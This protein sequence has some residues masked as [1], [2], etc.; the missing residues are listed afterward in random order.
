MIDFFPLFPV[1]CLLSITFAQNSSLTVSVFVS[2]NGN[3]SLAG[4]TA[5]TAVYSAARFRSIVNAAAATANATSSRLSLNVFFG[6]GVYKTECV[7]DV[8]S[9]A[10]NDALS[11]VGDGTEFQCHGAA[12]IFV[13]SGYWNNVTIRGLSVTNSTLRCAG[14]CAALRSVGSVRSLTLTDVHL[15]SVT[16]VLLD[17]SSVPVKTGLSAI[18]AVLASNLTVANCTFRDNAVVVGNIDTRST[19]KSLN[20]VGGAIIAVVDWALLTNVSFVG[21]QLVS[22]KLTNVAIGG[23]AVRFVVS[24]P[25]SMSSVASIVNCTFE[26]NYVASR[27]CVVGAAVCVSSPDISTQQ[28]VPAPMSLLV[29]DSTFANNQLVTNATI[30]AIM[31]G[32]AIGS[33]TANGPV[34]VP[35]APWYVL[36]L[37]VD[38]VTFVANSARRVH[39]STMPKVVGGVVQAWTMHARNSRFVGN[40]ISD[41]E[42]V[43]GGVFALASDSAIV[44]CTMADNR[45]GDTS[46]FLGSVGAFIYVTYS[47]CF[48]ATT[49]VLNVVGSAFWNNSMSQAPAG[50]LIGG[51]GG[52]LA[53]DLTACTS[54]AVEIV[55]STF[56]DYSASRGCG[57]VCV[58]SGGQLSVSGAL[59]A[60]NSAEFASAVSATDTAS[61]SFDRTR[62]EHNRATGMAGAVGL[63][64]A[65]SLAISTC[66]FD[67]NVAVVRGDA[68][69]LQGG[70]PQV[71]AVNTTFRNNTVVCI[72]QE[73]VLLMWR[74]CSFND[75]DMY[76]HANLRTFFWSDSTAVSSVV[77]VLLDV[78]SV[79]HFTITVT[80]STFLNS[81]IAL[82]DDSSVVGRNQNYVVSLLLTD[83]V[84]VRNVTATTDT[85]N[86]M[87]QIQSALF[88]SAV[89]YNNSF[90]G[91]YS[92][93][94][95]IAGAIRVAGVVLNVSQCLFADTSAIAGSFMLAVRDSVFMRSGVAALDRASVAP[96][97]ELSNVSAQLFVDKRAGLITCEEC[98]SFS[99]NDVRVARSTGGRALVECLQGARCR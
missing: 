95:P 44:N 1:L 22:S 88:S 99:L 8:S 75:S 46:G 13:V 45:L 81:P 15:A 10:T 62:F 14:P 65:G 69:L 60:N 51:Y 58:A 52:M 54:R 77:T 38:N 3:D 93:T 96:W 36:N 20:N 91:S 85:A 67:R 76:V 72:A 82:V 21:N 41:A 35:E 53:V 49:V 12:D 26:D 19:L 56:V 34:G 33:L 37:T 90:V 47:G 64:N 25:L 43:L 16:V 73:P 11:I 78:D 42:Y 98:E 94:A 83:N 2:P 86:A 30:S 89:L 28:A 70:S 63:F 6:S 71:D 17:D 61:V 74:Q 31:I 59:F 48:R 32:A 66:V 29:R 24:N 23:G 50:D 7:W 5:I 57:C 18:A 97:L 9:S 27:A 87:V 4:D 55:A 79:A 68:L 92:A 84:F 40:D 39:A 80:R